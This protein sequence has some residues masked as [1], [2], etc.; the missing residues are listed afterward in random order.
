MIYMPG[1]ASAYARHLLFASRVESS[2]SRACS[3]RHSGAEIVT[4]RQLP[5]P[6]AYKMSSFP[7]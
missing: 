2:Y 7:V 3:R 1:N 6:L 5:S 4:L